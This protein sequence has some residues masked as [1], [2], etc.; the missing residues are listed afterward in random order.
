MKWLH[1]VSHVDLGE[2]K[3]ERS[4]FSTFHHI[5]DVGHLKRTEVVV[6]HEFKQK[7]LIV[8]RGLAFPSS[9]SIR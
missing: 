9:S 1:H 2:N 6:E 7:R 5:D 4:K 8:L 3:E